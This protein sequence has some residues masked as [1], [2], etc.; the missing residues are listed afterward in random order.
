MKLKKRIF[1]A[2]IAFMLILT[3]VNLMA[4]AQ[5]SNGLNGSGTQD[6]PYLISSASQLTELNGKRDVYVEL[7]QDIDLSQVIATDAGDWY[8]FY[9]TDFSGT[10][11]GKGHKLYNFGYNTAF[12]GNFYG[13]ELK[14][15]TLEANGNP[16]GL[17]FNGDKGG[18]YNYTDINLTGY[19]KYSTD[20]NNEALLMTYAS[21]DVT[22]TRVHNS[23][24]IE[25]PT[26][27][28]LFI[29]SSSYANSHYTLTDCTYSGY[30]IMEQPGIVFA[31]GFLFGENLLGENPT[32]TLTVTNCKITGTVLGT[33]AAP[34][35]LSCVSFPSDGSADALEAKVAAGFTKTGTIDKTTPLTGYSFELNSDGKLRITVTD[36]NSQIGS[37]QVVSRKYATMYLPSGINAGTQL[38]NVS[39]TIPVKAGTTTYYSSLGKVQFY[40]GTDGELGTTGVNGSLN[41][42]KKDGKIGYLL[43]NLKLSDDY[44]YKFGAFDSQNNWATSDALVYVYN[45][46]GKLINIVNGPTSAEFTVPEL[47][48]TANEADTLS[49]VA[50][51]EGYTWVD[52]N[53]KV[54][55]GG[56][57]CFAKKD[58]TVIPV[59]VNGTPLPK[60]EVPVIDPNQPVEEIKAGATAD[61]K[62]VLEGI[63]NGAVNGS[64]EIVGADLQN[65]IDAAAAAGQQIVISLEIQLQNKSE[66]EQETVTK[67]EALLNKSA[68]ETTTLTVA[69]YFDISVLVQADQSILGN[70]TD[71]K[72]NTLTLQ[73]AIPDSLIAEGRTFK[74]LRVHEGT[75]ELLDA[76]LNG[77]L[78]TFETDRFSTY[79]LVAVDKSSTTPSTS[80]NETTSS[81]STGN[82]DSAAEVPTTGQSN[83][84]LVAAIVL[85]LSMSGLIAFGYKN[86]T[87][88]KK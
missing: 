75:A 41:I 64:S 19:V 31:N 21:G 6:D 25:S 47:S 18:T 40:D 33:K 56:Q 66:V 1:S 71:L 26:Y 87:R 12:I 62:E 23:A 29:G 52:G 78:L 85:L 74:V 30:A 86:S 60:A 58:N 17:V 15:L 67:I 76:T 5:N 16:C 13:G 3:T 80:D 63:I 9:I 61:T 59:N 32:S 55:A 65:K 35:Y 27:N 49:S 50:A 81:S 53:V 22:L 57:I 20:N 34:H 88:S 36:E 70:I 39:E 73:I 83:I 48:V 51:P 37:F 8:D 24:D 38:V 4:F 77:N 45:T 44:I 54:V 46:E 72:G 14:N 68:T 69:Q 84:P 11:D 79:A 43:S 2:V 82:Q 10:I 28:G 7:T 42:T